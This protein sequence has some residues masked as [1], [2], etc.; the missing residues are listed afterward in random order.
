MSHFKVA[1]AKIDR[2]FLTV[3]PRHKA[4]VDKNIVAQLI[5]VYK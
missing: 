2:S 5:K 3:I 1:K 4:S